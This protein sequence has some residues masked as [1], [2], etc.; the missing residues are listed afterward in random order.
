MEVAAV[1]VASLLSK[2]SQVFLFLKPFNKTMLQKISRLSSLA[3]RQAKNLNCRTFSAVGKSE[4]ALY[5][6][7][8]GTHIN[9]AKSVLINDFTANN[10]PLCYHLSRRNFDYFVEPYIRRAIKDKSSVI[11]TVDDV[12]AGIA[13][14]N[15]FAFR[16]NENFMEE[17]KKRDYFGFDMIFEMEREL[18]HDF[19]HEMHEKGLFKQ[20]NILRMLMVGVDPYYNHRGFATSLTSE[21]IKKAKEM[22][23]KYVIAACSNDY[24]KH[25]TEKCGF[26]CLNSIEYDKWE[27]PKQSGFY[28]KQ[29]IKQITGFNEIS[30]MVK[31]L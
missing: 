12:F 6:T 21:S 3:Q 7:F 5:S 26:E 30:F 20:G 25:A 23:Y 8:D 24:M 31:K 10:E 22:D 29:G 14:N 16:E 17:L 11:V 19:R 27:Y 1:F 4:D 13:L 9:I 28:P 2:L 18:N 15:D